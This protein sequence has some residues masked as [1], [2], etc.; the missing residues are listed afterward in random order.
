M[1]EQIRAI[2]QQH[3]D[4]FIPYK[5]R[6]IRN[7]SHPQEKRNAI[8]WSNLISELAELIIPYDDCPRKRIRGRYRINRRKR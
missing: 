7:P 1:R 5:S 4:I 2:E 8:I 6:Q 3:P